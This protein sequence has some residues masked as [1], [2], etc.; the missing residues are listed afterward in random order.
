MDNFAKNWAV[1]N[2]MGIPITSWNTLFPNLRVAFVNVTED[3]SPSVI[4]LVPYLPTIIK[5]PLFALK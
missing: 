2:P 4:L 3:S 1:S 5:W